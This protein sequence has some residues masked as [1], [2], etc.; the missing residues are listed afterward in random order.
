M[1]RMWNKISY[2]P[3]T[4][5][6]VNHVICN[7]YS[8]N[9]T[10]AMLQILFSLWCAKYIFFWIFQSRTVRVTMIFKARLKPHR[11][12]CLLRNWNFRAD[13]K[14]NLFYQY[15]FCPPLLGSLCEYQIQYKSV[16]IV[17]NN[18]KITQ[19]VLSASFS[20]SA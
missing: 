8:P 15:K 6:T 3:C 12:S 18:E 17:R 2:N 5:P 4:W 13:L 9:V 19:N 20:S 7:V 11:G 14:L 10:W 1:Q 16:M